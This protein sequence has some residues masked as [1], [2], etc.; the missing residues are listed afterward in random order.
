MYHRKT[1]PRIFGKR[2][3]SL[4]ATNDAWYGDFKDGGYVEIIKRSSGWWADIWFGSSWEN[5]KV[6][7]Q[8]ISAATVRD[9]SEGA[10][11]AIIQWINNM[12]NPFGLKCER[13]NKQK[14]Q[15]DYSKNSRL[16]SKRKNLLPP[17]ARA[18]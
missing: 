13:I 5:N 8:A 12:A 7:D 10:E 11:K 9:A 17:R 16:R 6:C 1:A 4:E 2:L 3:E 14:A 18:S 15:N